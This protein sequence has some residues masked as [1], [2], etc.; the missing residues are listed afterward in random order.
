VPTPTHA[1]LAEI[2]EQ[3]TVLARLLT[4][5]AAAIGAVGEVLRRRNPALVVFVARGTSHNAAIYGQYLVETLLRLPTVTAMPSVTTL[6]R[7][8]P[9]WSAGVVIG[10][11]QSGRSMDV[12]EVVAEARRQGA[13]TI[14]LT[15]DPAAPLAQH[16]A[17]VL[18][19]GAGPERAVAATKTF[20]ASLAVLAALVAGWAQ[21]RALGRALARVPDAAAAVIARA[22]TL[23]ALAR[24]H[25]RRE[26]W[27]VTT[28]GYMLGVADEAALKLKETAYAFAE[29]MSA[30]ELLHGPIA[31]LDRTRTVIL[32]LPPGRTRA[33]LIDLRVTLRQR[34][35]PTLT[36]AFGDD[37]GD[38]AADVRLPEALVPVAAA[39][40]VHL[41]AYYLSVARGLN[42]DAPRGLRKVTVT[43]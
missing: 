35:V 39:P 34:S 13:L 32:L 27:I 28:R 7:R 29:S 11:S 21:H 24:R 4:E 36:F 12:A 8:T 14:A 42:P 37:P 6:Y 33:S 23:R 17:H 10:I 25:A 41:F 20:T 2:Q 15:N 18:P 31:A 43:W 9:D 30:A 19:L 3:P 38:L 22:A 16:S 40:A 26:P 5:Q 1:M